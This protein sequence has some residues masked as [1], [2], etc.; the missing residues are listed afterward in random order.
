[1]FGRKY[2]HGGMYMGVI[3]PPGSAPGRLRIYSVQTKMVIDVFLPDGLAWVIG[4]EGKRYKL[5]DV[6]FTHF[7]LS[8]KIIGCL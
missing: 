4:M 7:W 5:Q 2:L 6:R 3:G 1:M 8:A